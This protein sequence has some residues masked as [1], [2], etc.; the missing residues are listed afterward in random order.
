MD[1][2]P[3]RL[4]FL[5]RKGCHL[6]HEARDLVERVAREYQV[7]LKVVDVDTRSE[8]AREYGQ[9]VPV[10]LVDGAKA[11]KFHV[12]ERRLRRRLRRWRRPVDRG[13][14]G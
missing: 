13:E 3:G 6:C 2:V 5:T 12:D 1:A 7:T 11:F 4:T 14:R 10:L 9:E 8:L